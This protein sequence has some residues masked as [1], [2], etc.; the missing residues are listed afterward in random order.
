[1]R[2]SRGYGCGS[3]DSL[4]VAGFAR[5]VPLLSAGDE[6]LRICYTTDSVAYFSL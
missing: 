4:V 1:M 6:P 2:C 5:E 3:A